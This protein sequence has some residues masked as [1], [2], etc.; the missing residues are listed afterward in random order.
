MFRS[1]P[2]ETILAFLDEYKFHENSR[3]LNS[4]AIRAYVERRIEDG[5]LQ[6]FS[7]AILALP[8]VKSTLGAMDLGLR[9]EVACIN[10][11]RLAHLGRDYA[12]IKTLMSR[13]DRLAD[14][15]VPVPEIEAM[16]IAQLA[17]A[18][19]V[20]PKGRGDGSGLVALYPIS[21]DSQPD[22]GKSRVPLDA[23]DHVLGVGLVF[24]TSASEAVGVD[25]MTADLS[26]IPR[27]EPLD[28]DDVEEDE[29]SIAA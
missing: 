17:S 8:K 26:S 24:P 9:S 21:K 19:D 20:P 14:L 1:V 3:D 28:E 5:E 7:V 2:A 16:D 29:E 27:E 23:V 11:A 22:R 6:L 18:R 25:Y 4:A 10:R 15:A 12:D 13:S